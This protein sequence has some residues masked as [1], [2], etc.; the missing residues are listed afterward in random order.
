MDMSQNPRYPMYSPRLISLDVLRGLT[1][2]LMIFVNN[3]AGPQIYASLQHSRWNGLTPCD[4]V[5]P[6]FLFMVGVSTYLSLRKSHFQYS[7]QTVRKIARRTALLFLLGLLINWFDM[8]CDGRPADLGHLRIMGVMQ[9]IALCYGCTALAAVG[10]TRLVGSTRALRY[11]AGALLMFYTLLIVL[12]GGY[13]YDAVT[14]ILAIADTH[15]LGYAHLYHKSPVDPEGLLST[16]PAIAHTIIGLLVAQNALG[17]KGDDK[18][19]QA[20][21][22]MRRFAMV[23]VMLAL[24]GI[25]LAFGLPLNKRIWSPSY[26]LL[27][28][29]LAAMA[30]AALIY[31]VD[32]RPNSHANATPSLPKGWT[33]ALIFGTNPLFL[34]MASEII[35]ILVGAT[36]LKEAAYNGLRTLISNGY[37]ASLAY[38]TLFVVLHAW[39]GYALWKR[40]IY[41]KI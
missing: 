21:E 38:A 40:K 35:A 29:G 1:V 37:V 41:I 25:A 3:G 28:C 5:F 7:A 18:P 9:R 11:L 2:M 39:M 13:N 31:L 27:T 30:Q 20:A 34:Y 16:L 15:L 33:G 12:G 22:S 23:G 8:A 10:L 26:V 19:T 14:N 36:G 6:F 24:A 4:L 17:H 32:R